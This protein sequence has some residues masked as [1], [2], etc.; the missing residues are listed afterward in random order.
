MLEKVT[1]KFRIVQPML[2]E[3]PPDKGRA[4]SDDRVT[5]CLR[6]QSHNRLL[7]ADR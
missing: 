1:A 5:R 7:A 6:G 3:Q 4:L 2:K